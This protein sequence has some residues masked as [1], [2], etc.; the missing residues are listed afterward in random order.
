MTSPRIICTPWPKWSAGPMV[1][2]LCRRPDLHLW[3]PRRQSRGDE[4]PRDALSGTATNVTICCRGATIEKYAA[5][6]QRGAI[7]GVAAAGDGWK[8]IGCNVRHMH[9]IAIK[10][11]TNGKCGITRSVTTA[12]WGRRAVGLGPPGR[13]TPSAATTTRASGGLGSRGDEIYRQDQPPLSAQQVFDNRGPGIWY[14]VRTAAPDRRQRDLRQ[15]HEG[16][17]YEISRTGT[18][19]N[20]TIRNNGVVFHE[21]LLV[22]QIHLQNADGCLVERN[23][24]TVPQGTTA[25]T[26]EGPM[27]S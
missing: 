1:L 23:A 15:L 16:I 22:G 17:K 9:G 8:V 24:V 3:R 13:T 20:N 10:A 27:G 2:R 21:W 18:I 5:P 26:N 12:R 19:R 7:G 14:D 11:G 25:D 6:A 4:H